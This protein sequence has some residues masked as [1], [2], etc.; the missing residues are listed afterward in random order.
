MLWV[1]L[2]LWDAELRELPCP[3]L[4]MRIQEYKNFPVS[5]LD[6]DLHQNLTIGT[7]MLIPVSYIASWVN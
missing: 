4:A 6:E 3:A 5:N 1:G 2:E 7:L